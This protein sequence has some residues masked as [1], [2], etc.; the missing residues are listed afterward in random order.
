M[1]RKP[2]IDSYIEPMPKKQF[3]QLM[4]EFKNEGGIYQSDE[5]SE[6]FL[7]IQGA[8]ACTLNEKTILFRRRPSRSAVYEELFHVSQ[9]KEGKID[10]TITAML[11]CEIEAQEYL[12]KNAIEFKLTDREII[13]TPN[14][15]SWYREQLDQMKGDNKDDNL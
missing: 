10:G 4:K 13:Q 7:D 11:L 14:A 9:Y 3:L 15:L 5:D 12:L 2:K 6:R 1:F 8:E